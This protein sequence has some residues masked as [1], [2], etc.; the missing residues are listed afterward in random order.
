MSNR[1][2]TKYFDLHITGLGYLNRVR[3][4]PVKRGDNFLAVNISA[5]HGRED[6][7][8]YTHFDT[9]VSGS[10]AQEVIKQLMPAIE[11]DKKVLIGFKLGDLYP[12]LFEYKNGDRKGETGVSLK[13]RLLRIAWAKVDG[14]MVYKAESETDGSQE[15]PASNADQAA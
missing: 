9:K 15:P 11:A 5:L 10:K 3:E 2:E 1:T 6:A 14:D 13:S 4:V 12:D 7:V 8:E